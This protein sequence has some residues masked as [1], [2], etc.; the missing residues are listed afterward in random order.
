MVGGG[1]GFLEDLVGLSLQVWFDTEALGAFECDNLDTNAMTVLRSRTTFR[2]DV[3]IEPP[4]EAEK[5]A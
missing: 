4:E 1:Y 2:P 5:Q 3:Q